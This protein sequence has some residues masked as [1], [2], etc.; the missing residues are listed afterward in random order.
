MKLELQ[1]IVLNR[2]HMC[3]SYNIVL[4]VERIPRHENSYA[5]YL[6]QIFDFDDWGVSKNSFNYSD[7]L[8]GPFTS[9][10]F[11]DFKNNKVSIFYT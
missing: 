10:R 1:E 6:S 2:F 7:T 4:D 8:Q 5:D 9:D 11:A 3:I